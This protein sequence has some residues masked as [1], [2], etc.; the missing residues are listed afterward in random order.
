MSASGGAPRSGRDVGS[1]GVDGLAELGLEPAPS[2]G[3]RRQA[4]RRRR[5]RLAV[6]VVTLAVLVGVPVL[7]AVVGAG[8]LVRLGASFG[9]RSTTIAGAL[10]EYEGRPA[11]DD[12]GAVDVLLLGSDTRVEGESGRSDTIMLVRLPADRSSVE[13]LSI[14]RDSW[15][16]VPGHGEAKINAAYSW[17]GVPLTVQTVEQLLEVRVDHVAEIDFEGFRA[18][19]DALGGV[20]VDSEQPFTAGPHEFRQG[21]NRLDGDAALAFV[22][23]RYSFADADHQRVRNQQAFLTGLAQGVVSR[24]TLTDP[25]RVSEFVG[26]TADHLAVDASLTPARLLE[27]GWSSRGLTPSSLHAVTLPVA[28]GGTSADGQS[29]LAIDPAGLESVREALRSDEALPDA[30]P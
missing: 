19:T 4:E 6:V 20:V 2:R 30:A 5:R 3:A 22:R 17:G 13:V 14:M 1:D 11:A 24:G 15:V 28:G 27:L 12:D 9:D 29:Y 21:L 8:Y 18:M 26:V 10:P 25:A 7:A 16:E 23:E